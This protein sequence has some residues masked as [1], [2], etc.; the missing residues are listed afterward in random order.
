MSTTV[1][2]VHH[3]HGESIGVATTD[4]FVKGKIKIVGCSFCH[5]ERNTENGIS[6]EV[7]L[8]FSTIKSKHCFVNLDLIK[9]AHANECIGDGAIHISNSFGYTFAH[10]TSFVSIAEL[11][12]FVNT[13]GSTRGN[14]SAAKSTAFKNHIHFNCRVATGIEH[15]TANDFFDFHNAVKT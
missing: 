6:T 8:C 4:I 5:C 12:S 1:D 9:S 15:L 3:R 10:V 13:G 2:D 14:R 7:A 11:K